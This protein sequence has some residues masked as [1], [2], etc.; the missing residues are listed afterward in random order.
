MNNCKKHFV[1]FLLCVFCLYLT[2]MFASCQEM[3]FYS[4]PSID[5]SDAKS[6]EG[7]SCGK[8][9]VS[10]GEV[11]IISYSGEQVGPVH[12]IQTRLGRMDILFVVDDSA[13]MM[14]ELASIAN[15]FDL[16]LETIK[17]VDYR[18]AITTTDW[19]E[20]QG[21]FLTFPNNRDFLDNPNRDHLIHSENIGYFQRTI[22]RPVGQVSDERGIYV[23]NQVLEHSEN[24]H[25]FRPHAVFVVIIVS[26]EDERSTGGR[27]E[28]PFLLEQND[29]PE[30]FFRRFSN[31]NKYSIVTVHS[32]IVPPGDISCVHQAGGVDGTIYAQ[33]S[34]PSPEILAKYGNIRKGHVGSICSSNYSSQLGP[35]A[36]KLIDVPS[37]PLPCFPSKDHISVKVNQNKLNFKVKGRKLL[38]EDKVSFG[39]KVEVSFRCL[40]NRAKQ[41]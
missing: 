30:T 19:I 35:I 20:N 7:L 6:V 31:K 11:E 33:A 39:A 38:I 18:I 27:G 13:S 1:L 41:G 15:Q 34:N 21:R 36:D 23:L 5:C 14:K 24:A 9:S 17:K 28:L 8:S 29:L 4:L 10:E 25:F 40:K 2:F 22:Q 26:D 16:F 32:I 12:T 3:D 37:F